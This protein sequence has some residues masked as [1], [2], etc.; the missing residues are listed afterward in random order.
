MP[1]DKIKGW[2]FRGKYCTRCNI[3]F[4]ELPFGMEL[5]LRGFPSFGLDR[6]DCAEC[7]KINPE[8]PPTLAEK[9]ANQRENLF[10]KEVEE[11]S[12]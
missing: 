8:N 6:Q 7:T 3:V 1:N 5:R 4:E 11:H 10:I 9:A 2:P 12:K